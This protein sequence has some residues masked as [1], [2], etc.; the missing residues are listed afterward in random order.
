MKKSASI[1]RHKAVA[2]DIGPTLT[3]KKSQLLEMVSLIGL[4]HNKVIHKVPQRGIILW[5][6]P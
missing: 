1:P 5:F 3:Y 6:D 4:K 2:N